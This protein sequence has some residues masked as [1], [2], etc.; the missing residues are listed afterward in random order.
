MGESGGVERRRRGRRRRRDGRDG[1]DGGFEDVVAAAA[2]EGAEAAVGGWQGA[3]ECGDARVA[4]DVPV[5]GRFIS[6]FGE[7][8]VAAV[9][10]DSVAELFRALRRVWCALLLRR[11][12]QQ[13]HSG[14]GDLRPRLVVQRTDVHDDWLWRGFDSGP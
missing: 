3:V 14:S 8:A 6:H 11:L 7:H 13:L 2:A 5:L 4:E 1:R 12:Q 9:C 10:R